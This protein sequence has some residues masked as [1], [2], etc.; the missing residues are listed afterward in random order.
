MKPKSV[1]T[2]AKS[3]SHTP[4]KENELNEKLPYSH[5]KR[6]KEKKARGETSLFPTIDTDASRGKP[7]SASCQSEALIWKTRSRVWS[8]A[9]A[10]P[11]ILLVSRMRLPSTWTT[12]PALTLHE[13]TL[14]EVTL[15]EVT[16]T[17][18][19]PKKFFLRDPSPASHRLMTKGNIFIPLWGTK[20]SYDY[21]LRI[22]SDQEL[23]C[24]LLGWKVIMLW[25]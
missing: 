21:N 16:L 15:H 9:V 10:Q 11:L 1:N 6:K 14:H 3:K 12:G 18:V 25:L 13:V 2:P 22:F 19:L 24:P 20:Q 4:L 23:R 7:W 17:R 5:C 8:R